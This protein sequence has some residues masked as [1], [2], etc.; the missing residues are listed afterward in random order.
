MPAVFK[1]PLVQKAFFGIVSILVGITLFMMKLE[2]ANIDKRLESNTLALTQLAS[3]ERDLAER[4]LA[5]KGERES[6]SLEIK[7]LSTATQQLSV[8]VKELHS[9]LNSVKLDMIAMSASHAN[10]IKRSMPPVTG[11]E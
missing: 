5:A 10:A 7:M 2:Y 11:N 3:K 1:D 8:D 6:R 4:V 9:M